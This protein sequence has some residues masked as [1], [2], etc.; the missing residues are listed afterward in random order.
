[1]DIFQKAAGEPQVAGGSQVLRSSELEWVKESVDG[2]WSKEL[3]SD[4]DTGKTTILMKVDAGAFAGDHTH[5]TLEQVYVIE[6]SF[7]DQ[8]TTYIAG[9]YVVRRAGTVHR[10]GSEDGALVLVVFG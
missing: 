3:Y 5:D 10:T 6:G 4:P 8:E 7:Y 9:D 2:F 1:M